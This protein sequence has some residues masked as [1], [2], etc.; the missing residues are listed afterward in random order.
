MASWVPAVMTRLAANIT[1]IKA[2]TVSRCS[3][4]MVIHGWPLKA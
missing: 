3:N 2:S 4:I 1:A